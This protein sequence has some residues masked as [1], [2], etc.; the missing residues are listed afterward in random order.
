MLMTLRYLAIIEY[1]N[2][3]NIIISFDTEKK[4]Q[5]KEDIIYLYFTD[6]EWKRTEVERFAQCP[7]SKQQSRD[8]HQW[9]QSHYI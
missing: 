8:L 1:K 2:F 9:F 6:E 7:T 3:A 5:C 4:N